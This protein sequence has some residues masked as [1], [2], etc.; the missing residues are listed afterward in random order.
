MKAIVVTKAG[1]PDVLQLQELDKPT[2]KPNEILVKV[3]VATVTRGDVALRKLPR[4]L[5]FI[6]GILAG[7]KAQKI[8]GVEFAG[9]IEQVGGDV[10]KFKIGDEVFGTT[11]GLAY[12]ANAEYAC[13]PEHWKQGVVGIKPAKLPFEQAATLPV[14]LQRGLQG[15]TRT[16]LTILITMI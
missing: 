15:S 5:L 6:V 1:T 7:F 12:G 4:V 9:T 8:P 14:G 11:T 16:D 13:L 3:K 10:Q 2:P